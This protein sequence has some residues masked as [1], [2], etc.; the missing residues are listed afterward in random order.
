VD[1]RQWVLQV[2]PNPF[3]RTLANLL[4]EVVYASEQRHNYALFIINL[5]LYLELS[6][7]IV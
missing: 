2:N 3:I 4:S 7:D 6:I 1:G 5:I